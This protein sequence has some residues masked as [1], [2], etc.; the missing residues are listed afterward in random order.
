VRLLPPNRSQRIVPAVRDAGLVW[1]DLAHT[2]IKME[3]RIVRSV[4]I[5]GLLAACASTLAVENSMVALPPATEHLLAM[6]PGTRVHQDTEGRVKMI[7]G[8]PMTAGINAQHAAEMWVM[9][10]GEAFGVGGLELDADWES[11]VKRGA[12]TVFSFSQRIAGIPVEYG[13]LRVLVKNGGVPQVVY[14]AGN[15]AAIPENL[16]AIRMDS[17]VA[18]AMARLSPA[19]RGL[20]EWDEADL[21]V[22][23]GEGE[24]VAPHIAWRMQARGADLRNAKTFFV[25]ASTGQVLHVRD[26]AHYIDVSGTLKA[27]RTPGTL[28]DIASNPPQLLDMPEVRVSISGGNSAYTAGNGTFTIPHAGTTSVTVNTGVNSGS[29]GGGR[30]SDVVPTGVAAITATH[31]DLPGG[32]FNLVLNA[33]PSLPNTA[34]VNALACTNITHTFFKDRAPGFTPIDVALRTNTGVSGSCNA[35]YSSSGNHSINFYNQDGTCVNSAYSTVVSH[36]YGHFIVNRLG[37]AQGGFGE[38]FSDTVAMLLWDDPIVGKNFYL[39]GGNIRNLLTANQ[40][41]PCSST[42]VHTCGQII[43]G[44]W[45][46]IRQNLGTAHGSGPGLELAR[47]LHNAWALITV[48]GTG[49][50]ALNSAHP[51]TVIEVLTVDDDDGNINNGTP[52]R[53]RICAA[54]A[55]HNLQCPP[56]HPVA[57][58]FPNGRPDVVDPQQS[59]PITVR[60]EPVATTP[61]A[62]TATV[63]YRPRGGSFT[64]APLT[65]LGGELYQVDFPAMNCGE[66]VEYYF[67]VNLTWGGTSV[68][69][70][71]APG[72]HFTTL[73]FAAGGPAEIV[74]QLNFETDPGWTVTNTSLSTGAWERAIPHT[75]P[76]SECP[77]SDS[78]GS[79]RCWVT[80]NRSGNYDVDGGPTTLT[81]GVY[82]LSSYGKID[83]QYARW[84]RSVNGTPD[85]MV[86]EVSSNG[87]QTWTMLETT[88][89]AVGWNTRSF[90][91]VAPTSQMRFR[92]VVSDNPNDSVTEA[93]LD[94]FKITGYACPQCYANCDGSTEPPVLNV[95]DF[96]CFL[97]RFAAG[98]PW[99]NCDGSTVPPVLNVSD[100][101]CFL[102]QFAAGCP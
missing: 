19:A 21:V 18:A 87:G 93:G 30:W 29:G 47:D 68:H 23:Q 60:I 61:V 72:N 98:D 5:A 48:G 16:N 95:A 55:A 12:F 75:P 35:F 7:Y 73:A 76:S 63:T 8:S 32:A 94:A 84:F 89:S 26:D 43:G 71:G 82:D 70:T 33:V 31:S 88:G 15:L 36:E 2:R 44:V 24:W 74:T 57:W 13:I 4:T 10:H 25:S 65:A 90:E 102:Q 34:Q 49:T 45:W 99:A 81:T 66:S 42:A 58:S 3:K 38:G 97:S 101:T 56:L 77:P 91:V 27:M 9:Q 50:N 1:S 85:S 96:S 78:D 40:Q 20:L 69:P 92:W 59:M 41:Y 28:P 54:F 17:M 37:L 52:N 11:E 83:V 67:G 39:S 64:T 53:D 80:D 62:G 86:F 22:F 46:K 6:Y 79:G 100:F 14:A 51:G